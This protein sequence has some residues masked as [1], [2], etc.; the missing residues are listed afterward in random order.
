MAQPNCAANRRAAR[1]G[2]V[3]YPLCGAGVYLVPPRNT[4]RVYVRLR[5]FIQLNPKNRRAFVA[6]LLNA[7][8]TVPDR[9]WNNEHKLDK[10]FSAFLS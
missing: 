5:Y 8:R 10:G 9:R 6:A 3:R 2:L 1:S 7:V 4:P